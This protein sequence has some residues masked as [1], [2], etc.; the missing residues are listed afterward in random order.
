MASKFSIFWLRAKILSLAAFKSSTYKINKLR[1]NYI[2]E[3]IPKKSY[4]WIPYN[5]EGHTQFLQPSCSMLWW[6]MKKKN[7]SHPSF[8][9]LLITR[10]AFLAKTSK[11]R[12]KAVLKVE[13]D[14]ITSI[15][16][17]PIGLAAILAIMSVV[18]FKTDVIVIIGE[19]IC[20]MSD[21]LICELG[22]DL[23]FL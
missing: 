16:S 20:L 6:W 12:I 22:T 4:K 2:W 13:T 15:T 10:L 11:Y 3:E 9:F 23:L 14:I 18:N 17:R 1:H 7:D 21:W 8:F 5:S 19:V